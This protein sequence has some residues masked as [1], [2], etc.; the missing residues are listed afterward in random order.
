[1]SLSVPVLALNVFL[2]AMVE[3]GKTKIIKNVEV[4]LS[5]CAFLTTIFLFIFI[6]IEYFMGSD[7][8][9]VIRNICTGEF[10]VIFVAICMRSYNKTV[11]PDSNLTKQSST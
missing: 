1:M 2:A 8:K 7:A 5:A 9:Q 10:F 3:H 4:T 11:K 6:L